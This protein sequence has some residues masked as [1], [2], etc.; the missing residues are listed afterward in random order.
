MID[1]SDIVLTTPHV[2]FANLVA[3]RWRASNLWS[4]QGLRPYLHLAQ[5][6]EGPDAEF[7]RSQSQ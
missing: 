2:T 5:G 4:L 1:S 3:V 7:R 6:Q